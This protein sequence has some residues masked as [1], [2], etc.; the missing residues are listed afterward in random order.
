[1]IEAL[2]RACFARL[3][4]WIAAEH[5]DWPIDKSTTMRAF[6]EGYAAASCV[7]FGTKA[8]SYKHTSRKS[9]YMTINE[10]QVFNV[11]FSEREV[12]EAIERVKRGEKP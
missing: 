3:C 11:Y 5:P 6:V 9:W 1:M 8:Y 12:L 2:A 4:P 7:V 10:V